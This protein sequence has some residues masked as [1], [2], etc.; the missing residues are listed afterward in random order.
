M[1]L[2]TTADLESLARYIPQFL[3]IAGR[4]AWF[5]RADHLDDEQKQSPF[6]WKIVADYH[7]LEM[8]VSYQSDVLT[9][10]GRLDPSL[11]DAQILTALNFVATTVQV[12]AQLSPK[13]KRELEGRLR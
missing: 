6:R 13:A 1:R 12:H 5:K 8:A 7:W 2:D 9:K 11:V 4:S 10:L 3:E